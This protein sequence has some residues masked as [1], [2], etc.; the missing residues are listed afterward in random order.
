LWIVP[1]TMIPQAA[2]QKG[3][4]MAGFGPDLSTSLF[5]MP[6]VLFYYAIFFGF[7]ALVY[8]SNDEERRLTRYWWAHLTL[9]L[10]VVLPLA[11]GFALHQDWTADPVPER[12]HRLL[13]SFLVVLFAWLMTFGT[14]GFFGAF[15]NREHPR[16][17]YLSDASYWLYLVHLPLMVVAQTLLL[18]SPFP[19]FVK[20]TLVLVAVTGILLVAYR[21][22]VRYTAIGRLL[23]GPRH[24]PPAK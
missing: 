23:N 19:T 10:F 6:H 15:L 16:L 17:R 20:F 5:P 3:G 21:Y 12:L 9:A 4:S 8:E 22:G 18:G 11:L 24:R 2:M 14:M 7:G 1:L 13:A